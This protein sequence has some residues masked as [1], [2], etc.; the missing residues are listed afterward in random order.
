MAIC[1]IRLVVWPSGKAVDC[2]S[3]I[4]SSNLGAAYYN[5]SRL[6]LFYFNQCIIYLQQLG[7]VVELVDT[8]DLKSVA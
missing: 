4:P 8:T 2:K 7:D 6:L 1:N 5:F 3:S